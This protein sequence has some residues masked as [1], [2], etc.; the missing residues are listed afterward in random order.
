MDAVEL[1]RS[2]PYEEVADWLWTGTRRPGLRFTA[3]AESLAAARRAVGALPGHS[4]STD[5][6]R[7]AAIAAAVADPLRFDL[8][9]EAVLGTARALIP[10]L[11]DALP[12]AVG[13]GAGRTAGCHDAG[14]DGVAAGSGSRGEDG[15]GADTGSRA[16]DGIAARL[17][18]RLTPRPPG[19]AALRALDLALSLLI[20]HDLA[21]STLAVRVA[22][23]ARAHPYAV[24][25]AGLGAMDGPLHGAAS[26]LAHRMLTDVLERG[27][28]AAVVSDH[29]RAGRGFRGSAIA[30]TRVRTRGPQRCSPRSTR[31]PTRRRPW[32]RR[33]E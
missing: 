32:P 29:L 16:D 23:S 9:R 27:S 3:P 21:A 33:A 4:G 22:A 6:L 18:A 10:T 14:A 31:C 8:S 25:S 13:P 24:V 17:W 11:V 1:A 19:A 12:V 15:S 7:V 5:R 26:G 20:D 30:C 2:Y 28:A